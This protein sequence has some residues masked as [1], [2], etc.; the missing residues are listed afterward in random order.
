ML[1][2]P[3]L[4]FNPHL[5]P[6][7]EF[8]LLSRPSVPR[9]A[10]LWHVCPRSRRHGAVLLLSGDAPVASVCSGAASREG[11]LAD[12]L[13]AAG[14]S[15]SSSD[16]VRPRPSSSVLVHPRPRVQPTWALPTSAHVS[17]LSLPPVSLSP[18]LCPGLA[19]LPTAS[20][21]I[22]GSIFS[23][24]LDSRSA[25]ASLPGPLLTGAG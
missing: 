18:S 15:P 4:L 1:S 25:T 22:P 17:H 13:A 23:S 8:L 12:A 21:E 14:L 7:A 3:L 10:A 2:L 24:P 16:L 5:Q 20:L 9:A 19:L 6:G 11:R